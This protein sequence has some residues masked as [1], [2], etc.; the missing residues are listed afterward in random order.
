MGIRSHPLTF[1]CVTNVYLNLFFMNA[2]T[3]INDFT[4]CT[5]G[6]IYIEQCSSLQYQNRIHTYMIFLPIHILLSPSHTWQIYTQLKKYISHLHLFVNTFSLP[7]IYA[8]TRM[9]L[10]YNFLAIISKKSPLHSPGVLVNVQSVIL[11][12]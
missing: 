1:T 7:P 6:Y 11:G 2:F 4:S 12:S 3:R 5:N 8:L 10:I 9:P